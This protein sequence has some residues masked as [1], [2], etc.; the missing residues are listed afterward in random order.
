MSSRSTS[1][2]CASRSA[3]ALP[4]TAPLPV[5][6][7]PEMGEVRAERIAN[8]ERF[9]GD[10][11]KP[12]IRTRE[13]SRIERAFRPAPDVAIE[14]VEQPFRAASEPTGVEL[15]FRPASQPAE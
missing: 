6:L 11:T 7:D 8:F 13:D 14:Q 10:S 5:P 1:P 4:N 9:A 15:A 2:T 12:K 3:S